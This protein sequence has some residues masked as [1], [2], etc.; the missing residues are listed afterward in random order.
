MRFFPNLN[1]CWMGRGRGGGVRIFPNLSACGMGGGLLWKLA[2]LCVFLC[3]FLALLG[4]SG[5]DERSFSGVDDTHGGI[6]FTR[7]LS[8]AEAANEGITVLRLALFSG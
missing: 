2:C 5:S 4:P 1:A 3:V 8:F 7:C 6:C